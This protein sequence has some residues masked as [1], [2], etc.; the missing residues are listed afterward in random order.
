MQVLLTGAS[1]FVGG[2]LL[3][4]LQGRG[5]RIS[6]LVRSDTARAALG[7][8]AIP[9][10]GDLD[11]PEGLAPA[12]AQAAPD[13]VVHLAAR[14]AT[15]RD[16]RAIART[17]TRGTEHLIQ[18][19][20]A[21]GIRRFVFT[22]TVVTGEADGALLQEDTPLPV[23]SAYGRSKQASEATL[24]AAADRGDMEAVVLRPSHVYG[25]G[26]WFGGLVREAAAGRLL[27]PGS[28][29]NYWDM[30]HVDDLVAALLI[31]VEHSSPGRLYHVA[32]DTPVRMREV[33]S[34][35]NAALGRRPPRSVPVWLARLIRGRPAIDA[36]V[37]SA[38]S[39]NT[40]IKRELGWS[41]EHPAAL[42]VIPALVRALVR[43]SGRSIVAS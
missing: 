32:D 1:G 11:R 24:F 40:R 33:F 42:P 17:N 18:A 29:A 41:P 21:A 13:V 28:G 16:D 6:A 31:A 23:A 38:R 25:P 26:G 15:T 10:K 9:I 3:D 5:H 2:A 27:V 30:L 8:R 14:I 19:A 7:G 4:A 35:I 36:A 34:A 43:A 39:S 12:L 22:S 20:T 37:R